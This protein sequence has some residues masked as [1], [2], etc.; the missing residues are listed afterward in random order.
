[1]NVEEKAGILYGKVIRLISQA[2]EWK[3]AV[4]KENVKATWN[5]VKRMNVTECQRVWTCAN[6]KALGGMIK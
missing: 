1:M 5:R 6:K 2:N 4:R 3:E